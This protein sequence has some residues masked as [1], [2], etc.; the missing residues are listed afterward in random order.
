M[1]TVK[2]MRGADGVLAQDAEGVLPESDDTGPPS[3]SRRSDTPWRPPI[4]LWH[5]YLLILL[6]S[7]VYIFFWTARVAGDMRRH[8]NDE[9]RPWH[10]V[11]G[12]LIPIAGLFVV[13]KQA[14]QIRQLNDRV[15]QRIGPPPWVI[16]ILTLVVTVLPEMAEK[17]LDQEVWYL[18]TATFLLFVALIAIPWLLMQRQLNCFKLALSG[19]RWS[20]RPFHFSK[21]QYL[22][23]SPGVVAVGLFA[24]VSHENL[25]REWGDHLGP[26]ETVSG[27]SGL[28]VLSPPDDG[29]VRVKPGTIEEETDLELYGSSTETWVVAYVN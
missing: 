11:A 26:G 23:L 24:F 28:Y 12:L 10:Y 16:V 15:D 8:V 14:S 19:A 29:W 9:I 1:T 5:L 3:S 2:Q 21:L 13:H 4:A 18:E 20:G 25:L 27:T 6:T 7:G 22:A 17:L